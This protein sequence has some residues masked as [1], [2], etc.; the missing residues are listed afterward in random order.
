MK[1]ML[2]LAASG[3]FA[4][5]ALTLVQAIALAQVDA[6]EPG[7]KYTI[8]EVMKEAHGNKLLDKVAS[9]EGTAEDKAKL[10]DL[11]ISL[12]ESEAPQGDQ[13]DY[14]K[15]AN[16]AVVAAARVVVGRDGAE[17]QL[18]KGVNCA[19]CHKGHKPPSE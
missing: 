7:P 5:G 1:K 13:A 18:K 11:Y 4:V 15:L 12:T 3:A 19:V 14:Q 16:A 2:L 10:L 8:K 9:G 6:D 17:E